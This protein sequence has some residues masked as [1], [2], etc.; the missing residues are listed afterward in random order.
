MYKRHIGQHKVHAW[1]EEAWNK[2]MKV[3]QT[4]A[5]RGSLLHCASNFAGGSVCC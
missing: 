1:W 4:M 3:Q 5:L 2:E